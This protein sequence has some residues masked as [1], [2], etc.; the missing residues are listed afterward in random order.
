[1]GINPELSRLI[2]RLRRGRGLSMERLGELVGRSGNWVWKV[3]HGQAGAPSPR[4][5]ADLSRALG[6]N[7]DELLSA[8]GM[9]IPLASGS[10]LDASGLLDTVEDPDDAAVAMFTYVGIVAARLWRAL[11]EDGGEVDSYVAMAQRLLSMLEEQSRLSRR[12]EVARRTAD[13]GQY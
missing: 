13:R 5:L 1:M 2:A 9:T 7:L 3:E 8:S 12:P 11:A 6:G 10:I 4:L